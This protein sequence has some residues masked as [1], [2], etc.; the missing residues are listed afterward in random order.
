[1]LRHLP[2]LLHGELRDLDPEDHRKRYTPRVNPSSRSR[3]DGRK[4]ICRRH[5]RSRVP[6]EHSLA[7]AEGGSGATDPGSARF[8]PGS[9]GVAHAFATGT[10]PA[11]CASSSPTLGCCVRQR[12]QNL[13]RG[14]ASAT[15]SSWRSMHSARPP[16]LTA[17]REATRMARSAGTG[18]GETKRSL[19]EQKTKVKRSAAL[20]ARRAAANRSAHPPFEG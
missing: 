12:R 14:R 7:E 2:K 11:S 17:A 4:L 8:E 3:E 18:L 5:A 19:H 6:T 16:S 1:V 20:A 15:R 9:P 13:G 10:G